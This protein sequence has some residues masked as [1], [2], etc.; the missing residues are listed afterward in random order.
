MTIKEIAAATGVSPTTVANVVHERRERMS[1][2][3]YRKV[4]EALQSSQYFSNPDGKKRKGSGT[5]MIAVVINSGSRD[6]Q[7]VFL[8]P[9][10]SEIIGA[11]E[12][13]I[14]QNGYYM[15]LYVSA[16]C[17]EMLHMISCQNIDGAI[18]L[19]VRSEDIQRTRE[20]L[21]LPLVFVDAY[22]ED[23]EK[24]YDNVGLQDFEGGYDM[25]KYLISQGHNRIA[26]MS[27][28]KRLTGVNYERYEGY[29]KALE[30]NGSIHTDEDYYCLPLE[31]NIR[32]EMLRRFC[33]KDLKKY[34]A[35]FFVADYYAMDAMEVFESQ[36]IRVPEDVSV[37]GFDD[38]TYAKRCHPKLTTMRQNTSEK[39]SVAVRQLLK[40][41]NDEKNMLHNLRL[42]AELIVRD[43]VARPR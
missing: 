25:T 24:E 1:D 28:E 11:I 33:K 8:S 30:E 18:L 9:F 42:P 2:E 20:Y 13:E 3:T 19:S 23:T 5:G 34:T 31:K 4:K 35:V 7:N 15:M 41:V 39:G 17:D 10:Y 22:W 36:K 32:Y 16:D 43:S 26:F 29:K 27:D 21:K 14:R 6:T 40:L 38:N 12:K 37:A